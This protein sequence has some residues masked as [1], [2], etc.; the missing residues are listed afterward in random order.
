M[1]L[2]Q[3]LIT[4][5]IDFACS[6]RIQNLVNAKSRT[7]LQVSLD[8][9]ERNRE[10]EKVFIPKMEQADRDKL[11]KGWK[12]AVERSLAWEEE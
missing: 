11:Y 7:Q 4:F 3:L 6:L 12:R 10:V 5:F 9:I 1:G 8:E 2:L